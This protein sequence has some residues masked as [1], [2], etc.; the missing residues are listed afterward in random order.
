MATSVNPPWANGGGATITTPN[1][2]QIAAGFS[3]GPADPGLFNFLFKEAFAAIIANETAIGTLNT[4]AT[5]GGF[6]IG[7]IV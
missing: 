4:G 6:T 3:C 7:S 1:A 5:G 2:A